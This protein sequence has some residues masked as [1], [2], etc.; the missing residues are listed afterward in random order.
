VQS[1]LN[2]A[3]YN[4]PPGNEDKISSSRRIERVDET[5]TLFGDAKNFVGNI[6]RELAAAFHL[7]LPVKPRRRSSELARRYGGDS[8]VR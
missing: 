2:T 8:Q 3:P 6:V 4:K 7:F 5:L 1:G